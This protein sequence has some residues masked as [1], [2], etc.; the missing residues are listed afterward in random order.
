MVQRLILTARKIGRRILLFFFFLFWNNKLA[1]R[2]KF[3]VESPKPPSRQIQKGEFKKKTQ[4]GD[5]QSE[6]Q[7]PS[8]PPTR[9]FFFTLFLVCLFYPCSSFMPLLFTLFVIHISIF[10][11]KTLPKHSFPSGSLCIFISA[12]K[13]NSIAKRSISQKS[14]MY[15]CLEKIRLVILSTSIR[16]HI[17]FDIWQISINSFISPVSCC[18][19]E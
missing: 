6:L 9:S 11:S 19:T 8:A 3:A 13:V 18:F 7:L 5:I 2:T 4:R 16:T 15:S 12:Y 10:F 1:Q 17:A 14:G